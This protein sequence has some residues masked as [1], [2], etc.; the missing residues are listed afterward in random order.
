MKKI[1]IILMSILMFSICSEN[2]SKK[3]NSVNSAVEDVVSVGKSDMDVVSEA[4]SLD[5]LNADL[6]VQRARLNLTNQKISNAIRDINSAL[7]LD[8]KN[9]EE[10]LPDYKIILC[11]TIQGYCR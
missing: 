11:N 2:I 9:I 5:S 6:Y 7:S 10:L 4:I 8:K 3:N 1:C